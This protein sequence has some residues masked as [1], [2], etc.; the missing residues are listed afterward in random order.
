MVNFVP[1]RFIL[2][3]D[4]GRTVAQFTDIEE[5]PWVYSGTTPIENPGDLHPVVRINEASAKPNS[6]FFNTGQAGKGSRT[7]IFAG[8]RD[9][10]AS[11]DYNDII[12]SAPI[13]VHDGFASVDREVY[14]SADRS[15]FTIT[16]P[17]QNLRSS[18][19]ESPDGRD[20]KNIIEVGDPITL[21]NT[22]TAGIFNP[23]L[24]NVLQVW[25]AVFLSSEGD[26]EIF[27]TDDKGA[28][29]KDFHAAADD[30]ASV[31]ILLDDNN[32]FSIP[33]TP[34]TIGD[35]NSN[36]IIIDT[37]VTI[38]DITKVAYTAKLTQ[39]EIDNQVR[40]DN[41]EDGNA[42]DEQ[43]ENFV[44]QVARMSEPDSNDMITVEMP[45]YNLL[46]VDIT[47]LETTQG[48]SKLFAKIDAVDP[49]CMNQVNSTVAFEDLCTCIADS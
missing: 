13:A 38:E 22:R 14:D 2:E 21:V 47:N 8:E 39:E 1:E 4:N 34:G 35:D 43:E 19:S 41:L 16:D 28:N 32:R 15:V 23:E 10:V 33:F 29:V 20:A 48:V 24:D 40:V 46:H 27:G 37:S 9:R 5:T 11:F 6:G 18:V 36:G 3:V 44:K 17:D 7:T 45:M 30:I 42:I 31:G 25:N 12:T 49:D 26:T